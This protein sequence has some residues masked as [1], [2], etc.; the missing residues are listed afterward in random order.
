MPNAD[1]RLVTFLGTVIKLQSHEH[2]RALMPEIQRYPSNLY[3]DVYG[4]VQYVSEADAATTTTYATWLRE[5]C[6]ERAELTRQQDLLARRPR[7]KSIE[8]VDKCSNRNLLMQQL[9]WRRS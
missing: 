5:L 7:V 4:D 9:T 3:V 6:F 2:T 1:G 8:D